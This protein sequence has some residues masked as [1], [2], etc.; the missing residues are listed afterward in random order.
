MARSRS[1]T[2]CIRLL[3]ATSLLAGVAQPVD[4]G[5]LG[6]SV[7][8]TLAAAGH[9]AFLLVRADAGAGLLLRSI[10]ANQRELRHDGPAYGCASRAFRLSPDGAPGGGVRHP[11]ALRDPRTC[12]LK[13]YRATAPPA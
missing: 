11:G 2:A 12:R 4:R 5:G 10:S 8:A 1:L 13:G 6:Q 7:E 9:D 3:V